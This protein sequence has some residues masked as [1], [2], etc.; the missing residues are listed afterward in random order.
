MKGPQYN[1]GKSTHVL[2]KGGSERGDRGGQVLGLEG[3]V[4]LLRLE[5]RRA[6]V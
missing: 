4:A 3:A 1:V 2:D 6:H 5:I